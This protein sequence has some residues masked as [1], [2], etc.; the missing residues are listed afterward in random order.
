MD[1]DLIKLL[2]VGEVPSDEEIAN[3]LYEVCDEE[4][5]SCS[6]S[7]C[8][9]RELNG[10]DAPGHDKPFTDNRGCDCFK[11]GTAMLQF[12][13]E[14]S[15]SVMGQQKAFL[16]REFNLIHNAKDVMEVLDYKTDEEI[17]DLMNRLVL[18]HD[19]LNKGETTD[20]KTNIFLIAS[21]ANYLIFSSTSLHA[22]RV[23]LHKHYSFNWTV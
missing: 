2:A 19:T 17:D 22:L 6:G 13:R 12:I 3:F 14:H 11:N 23:A 15:G 5:S 10:G 8:P 9:V 1:Y 18:K 16:K 20:R 21:L 7:G 4:H